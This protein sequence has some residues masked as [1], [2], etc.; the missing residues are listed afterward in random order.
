M[1]Q[2]QKLAQ[3]KNAREPVEAEPKAVPVGRLG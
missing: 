3:I 2:Q 1:N